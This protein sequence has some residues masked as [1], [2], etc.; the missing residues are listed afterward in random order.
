MTLDEIFKEKSSQIEI[1]EPSVDRLKRKYVNVANV[2]TSGKLSE[3]DLGR[4]I[5]IR[6]GYTT[7]MGK[8]HGYYALGRPIQKG[9]IFDIYVSQTINAFY[10]PSTEF[11]S[12]LGRFLLRLVENGYR[13]NTIEFKL[14][15]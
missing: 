1:P 3:E 4:V 13:I 11:R 15:S 9:V 5:T 10:F 6:P 2:H 12:S 14:K 8:V 7:N